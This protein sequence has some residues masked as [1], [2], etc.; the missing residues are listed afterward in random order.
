MALFFWIAPLV[1]EIKPRTSP[2]KWTASKS[3]LIE[4]I[5]ALHS[6]GVFNNGKADIKEIAQ[7]FEQTFDIDLGQNNRVFYDIRA[8]KNNKTK[9]LDIIREALIKRIKNTDNELFL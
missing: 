7:Y 5:Y 2:I 4:S 8:R 1:N 6:A 3:D 9:F